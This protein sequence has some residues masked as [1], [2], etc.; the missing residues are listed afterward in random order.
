MCQT[1]AVPEIDFVL[2]WIVPLW[3]LGWL[4]FPISSRFL[5]SLPDVGLAAGRSLALV[6]LV[7]AAFWLA[8]T[9]LVPLNIAPVWMCLVPIALSAGW[10]QPELRREVRAR[11]RQLLASDAVFLLSFGFFLWVRMRNPELDTNEKPMDS[12]LM[13]GAMR[14]HFLPFENPWFAGTAFTN[15]YYFGP[16]TGGLLA[17]LFAIPVVCAYNL[18]QPLYCATFLSVLSSVCAGVTRSWRWGIAAA[19]LVAIG[20]NLEPLR[21]IAQAHGQGQPWWPLDW[22]GTSRV[23]DFTINE[24]PAYTLFIG[25]THA[26]FYAFSW[27][28]LIFALAWSLANSEAGTRRTQLIVVFGLVLG[29]ILVGNTWD[30]PL[31]ALL[32]LTVA[33]WVGGRAGR[34]TRTNLWTLLGAIP[35]A[36]IVAAPY[37]LRFTP[38]VSGVVWA[39]WFPSMGAFL[40]IWGAWLPLAALSLAGKQRSGEDAIALD[41]SRAVVGVGMVA[42]ALPFL[43]YIR[44]FFGDGILR[45]MDTVYKFG[46]QAW[47]LLGTGTACGLAIRIRDGFPKWSASQKTVTVAGAAMLLP[48]LGLCPAALI[49]SRAI[50]GVPVG[51]N[52]RVE[53]TLDG[54]HLLDP[55]ESEGI[56][57]LRDHAQPG[58]TV[59]ETECDASGKPCEDP[60]YGR[61][62][63]L[64]GV[65]AP[66]GWFLH[67]EMWGANPTEVI[68]RSKAVHRFFKPLYGITTPMTPV[69]KLAL[70]RTRRLAAIRALNPTY[71]FCGTSE[72]EDGNSCPTDL[73]PNFKTVFSSSDETPGASSEARVFILK[74]MRP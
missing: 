28:A 59:L 19:F 39:P 58:D 61:V 2:R 51:P 60:R 73:G 65:P 72:S 30:A 23:I 50:A 63:G 7:L 34:W 68:R 25:D 49:W 4:V 12:M 5:T 62:S 53:L 71:I 29:A 40:L 11:W 54:T 47:L 67:V 74:V 24:Y 18:V 15:Y 32:T 31:Y 33:L 22:F 69:Q 13:A 48:I 41:F 38:Q 37:F 20:G 44:G 66:V 35:I 70:A 1:F 26:H 16:L 17:R 10:R 42:L 3:L 56:A 45:H 46:L 43:I 64:S 9:H 36:L 14:A 27:A 6:V 8:A 21:Q 57:W 55:A 52:G